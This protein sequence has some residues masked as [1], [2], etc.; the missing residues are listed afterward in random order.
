ML[1]HFLP[2]QAQFLAQGFKSSDLT[3]AETV[4]VFDDNLIKFGEVI[5]ILPKSFDEILFVE[6][7]RR[8][9]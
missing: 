1:A 3:V 9:I 5:D 2:P 6:L 7:V 8:I 4:P